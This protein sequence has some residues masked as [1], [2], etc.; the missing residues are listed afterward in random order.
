VTTTT[1]AANTWSPVISSS[2][3]IIAGILNNFSY[4]PSNGTTTSPRLTNFR[5]GI[6]KI[7]F[8]ASYKNAATNQAIA[9]AIFINGV[10][11]P[12][13]I[14][15]NAAATTNAALHY[16]LSGTGIV[17]MAANSTIDLRISATTG[18]ALPLNRFTV[19]VIKIA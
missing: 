6:F 19:N 2:A 8:V 3:L 12:N 11:Q 13:L 14:G 18:I 7:D 16:L 10:I 17:S 9:A 4:T 15:Q 5:A 1:L